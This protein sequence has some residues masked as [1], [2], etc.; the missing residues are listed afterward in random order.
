MKGECR[1][2]SA[3]REPTTHAN[4]HEHVNT[5]THSQTNKTITTHKL[6]TPQS[7]NRINPKTQTQLLVQTKS[8]VGGRGGSP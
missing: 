8:E 6:T 2:A 3:D 7:H 5:H 1:K 4:N